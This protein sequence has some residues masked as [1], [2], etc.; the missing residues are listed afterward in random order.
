M[1]VGYLRS[2]GATVELNDDPARA[3]FRLSVGVPDEAASCHTA[4][5]DGYAIEGHVPVEAIRRLLADRP[6]AVGLALPGMP[7]D[8]PGMGGD[9]SRWLGQPVVLVSR[10]RL[11]V[12]FSY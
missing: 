6:D 10:D 4:V 8:S 7:A 9:H 12:P 3:Q 5:L 11:L 2:N 1:W